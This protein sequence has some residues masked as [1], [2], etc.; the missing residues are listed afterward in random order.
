MRILSDTLI[1]K[2]VELTLIP[3]MGLRTRNRIHQTVQDI[4]DL[5]VRERNS[6]KHL[7][8]SDIAC[9]AIQS[10]SCRAAAEEIFDW[11]RRHD[12]R[13]LVRG[14]EGYPSLLE[15]IHDAP[16][17]LY[18]RGRLADLDSPRIAIV[19]SRRPTLYGLQAARGLAHDLGSRGVCIVS[20]LAR[21]VDA[22]AHRGCMETEGTTIAVL[23]CGID[24]DYPP[25]HRQ[26]KEKI[27]RKGLVLSE[28]PPGTRPAAH[29]FPVRNRVISGLS[30]GVVVVEATEKSGSLIT[31][32]LAM[33]QNRD[34]FALPGNI[35][36][37]ASYGPN[38]LI[39]QGAKLVQSYRDVIEEMPAT[40]Q[41]KIQSFDAP[42]EAVSLKLKLVSEGE[43]RLLSLLKL[44]EAI[45]FDKLYHEVGMEMAQLSE[46]LLNLELEGWV[47]RLP[48]NMYVRAECRPDP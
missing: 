3:G 1:K 6:L 15:E 37:P 8:L 11:A 17:V 48:G 19:G 9:R 40:L 5:F 26:L 20:G 16:L 47:R 42:P 38:F 4:S 25:E 12:C 41:L 29:N 33:E 10:R 7:G 22:A 32:R 14:T 46:R 30:L 31:A 34:V 23:G 43:K 36:S 35:T 39:K 21:G 18:A 27:F 28:F 13:V 2:A 45:H 24:V 44:D